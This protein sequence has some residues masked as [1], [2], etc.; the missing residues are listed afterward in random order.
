[1][2]ITYYTKDGQPIEISPGDPGYES[3]WDP[4]NRRVAETTIGGIWVSTVHLPMD[5]SF[6]QGPPLIFET[7]VFDHREDERNMSDEYCDR[8]STQEEALEGHK[9]AV[10]W[11]KDTFFPIPQIEEDPCG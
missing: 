6:G 1:M 2:A 9:K 7:M 11:V 4:E 3:L 5:H 8:Y 10:Q